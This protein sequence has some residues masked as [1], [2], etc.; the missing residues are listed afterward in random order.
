MITSDNEQAPKKK[1]EKGKIKRSPFLSG[2]K[3]FFVN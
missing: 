3:R 2:E 1:D